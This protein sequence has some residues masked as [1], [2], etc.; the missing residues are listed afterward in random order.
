MKSEDSKRWWKYFPQGHPKVDSLLQ[1]N[2]N[3]KYWAQ[4]DMMLLSDV[5]EEAGP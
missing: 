5:K 3:K 4:D 2:Q 1:Y